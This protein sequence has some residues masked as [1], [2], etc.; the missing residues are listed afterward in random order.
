MVKWAAGLV[1]PQLAERSIQ[2]TAQMMMTGLQY[3]PLVLQV[4][5]LVAAQLVEVELLQT[6]TELG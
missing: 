5:L 3:G 1:W 4:G 6:E 2:Q